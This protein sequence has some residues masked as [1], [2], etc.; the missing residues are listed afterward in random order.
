MEMLF[1]DFKT[2]PVNRLYEESSE[3]AP[4]N[5]PYEESSKLKQ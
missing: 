3:T 5:R 4:V 2:E 1:I